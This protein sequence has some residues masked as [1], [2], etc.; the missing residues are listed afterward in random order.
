[1]TAARV[2]CWRHGRTAHNHGGRWQGQLDIELDDVGRQQV[3]TAASLLL[4]SL[5]LEAPLAIVASDLRRASATG[6][7]LA[8]LAGVELSLDT[9]L[10]EVDVGAWQGL[11]RA[12]IAE[13]GMGEDLEAW[14]R[15]DD[16]RVGGGE[17]RSQVSLRGAEAIM[18]HAAKQDGGTLVVA[19]HGAVLRGAIVALL[20]LGPARWDLLGVLGNARWACL[21]PRDSCWRLLG[22]NQGP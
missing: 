9:R 5:G 16:V 3:A 4:E 13:A 10:R 22:Y 14:R 20:G 15:G 1:M 8:E 19:S 7:V 2:I 17:L 21:E 11:T 18:E 12:E 6:A